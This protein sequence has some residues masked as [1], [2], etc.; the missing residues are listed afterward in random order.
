MSEKICVVRYPMIGGQ[1]S[2]GGF[3]YKFIFDRIYRIYRIL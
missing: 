3:F 1:G 2:D